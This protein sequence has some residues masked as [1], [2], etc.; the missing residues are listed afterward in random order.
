MGFYPNSTD[1]CKK[2]E[3][4]KFYCAIFRR[5]RGLEIALNV[6]KK[7]CLRYIQRLVVFSIEPFAFEHSE[8]FLTRSITSAERYCIYGT[9]QCVSLQEGLI[10]TAAELTN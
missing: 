3:N 1:S 5:N 2:P 4:P 9:K 10:V 8:K 7:I 6:V